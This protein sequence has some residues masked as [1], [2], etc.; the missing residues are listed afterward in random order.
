M[1]NQASKVTK[2]FLTPKQCHLQLVEP[3]NHHVNAAK[4]T[5]QTF[6]ANFIS[7]LATTNSKFPLQLWDQLTPQVK[8]HTQHAPSVAYRSHQVSLQSST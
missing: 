3:N 7:A 8:T 1:D 2:I 6:K 5:I 4:R